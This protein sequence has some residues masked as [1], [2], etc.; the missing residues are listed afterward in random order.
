LLLTI[1]D[2]ARQLGIPEATVR[3]YRDRFTAYIPSVR[4]E[5]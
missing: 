3:Y 4:R 2:M 1:A 5:E